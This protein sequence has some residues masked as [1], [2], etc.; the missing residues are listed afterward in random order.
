MRVAGCRGVRGLRYLSAVFATT[1]VTLPL[2][3]SSMNS[4]V[5]VPLLICVEE[6]NAV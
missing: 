4:A 6:H 3:E 2:A 1:R 5:W